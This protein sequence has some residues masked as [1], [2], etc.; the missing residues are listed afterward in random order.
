MKRLKTDRAQQFFEFERIRD[1]DGLR[2]T[3]GPAFGRTLIALGVLLCIAWRG[4]GVFGPLVGGTTSLKA[5]V[6]VAKAIIP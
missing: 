6:D 2:F 1:R 4:P 3:L 5:A